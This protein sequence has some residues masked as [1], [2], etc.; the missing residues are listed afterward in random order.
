MIDKHGSTNKEGRKM[1]MSLEEGLRLLG[2][3]DVL[4]NEDQWEFMLSLL[5]EKVEE[6]GE[7]WV[8]VHRR[9]FLGQW[10]YM[11]MEGLV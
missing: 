11:V 10:E 5:K 8:I 1:P 3:K 2:V 9:E 4:G 7:Q 6:R